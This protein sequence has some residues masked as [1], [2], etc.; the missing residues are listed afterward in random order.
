MTNMIQNETSQQTADT[1]LDTYP[2]WTLDKFS[3]IRLTYSSTMI[4]CN[5]SRE[6]DTELIKYSKINPL[7]PLPIVHSLI[8]HDF[9]LLYYVK[10]ADANP[11]TISPGNVGMPPNTSTTNRGSSWSDELT[12]LIKS[13]FSY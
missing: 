5:E 2:S 13:I 7:F 10:L 1:S 11:A 6:L 12:T 4:P 9:I 8:C 3:F